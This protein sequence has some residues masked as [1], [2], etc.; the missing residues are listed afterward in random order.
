MHTILSKHFGFSFFFFFAIC[1]SRCVTVYE[2]FYEILVP[3][4]DVLAIKNLPLLTNVVIIC[5]AKGFI[6]M[7]SSLNRRLALFQGQP[8]VWSSLKK[9][10]RCLQCNSPEAVNSKSKLFNQHY[11]PQRPPATHFFKIGVNSQLAISS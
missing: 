10:H 4:Q 9:D 3:S 7:A 1:E 6:L 5:I 8:I 11:T 2:I